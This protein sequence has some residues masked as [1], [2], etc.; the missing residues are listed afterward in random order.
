MLFTIGSMLFT[1]GSMLFAIGSMLFTIGSMLITI[2]SMLLTI[3]SILFTLMVCCLLSVVY[4]FFQAMLLIGELNTIASLV[5]IFFLLAYAAVNLA[6]LALDL[7]SAPN[8]R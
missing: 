8:F 5:S 2:G 7:A 1:I 3:C 6:C 4:H